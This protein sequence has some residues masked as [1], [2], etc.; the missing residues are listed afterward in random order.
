ME[1]KVLLLAFA[2][3]CVLPANASSIADFHNQCKAKGIPVETVREVSAGVIEVEYS[4]SATKAQKDQGDIDKAAFD[5][6]QDTKK[7]AS[8]A[9]IDKADSDTVTDEEY[10]K[11]VRI[12]NMK[13]VA[14]R[15]AAYDALKPELE[16]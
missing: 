1:L 8:K 15:D 6:S 14:K 4:A 3:L 2:L 16:K 10:A 5:F 12:S 13:D 11:L 7:E 9:L